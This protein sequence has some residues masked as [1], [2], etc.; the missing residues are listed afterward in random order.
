MRRRRSSHSAPA[1]STAAASSCSPTSTLSWFASCVKQSNAVTL[2]RFLIPP[3]LA[4][5]APT[6][7][8]CAASAF[9]DPALRKKASRF[10][11]YFAMTRRLLW[12][13][14]CYTALV[15]I[16]ASPHMCQNRC[17]VNHKYAVLTY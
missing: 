14:C 4:G 3:L 17:L 1:A 7:R 16:A 6:S 8:W 5:A 12:N 11:F 2:H 13:I 10:I 15:M 9:S